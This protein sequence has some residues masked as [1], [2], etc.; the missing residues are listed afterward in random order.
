MKIYDAFDTADSRCIND[1]QICRMS[2]NNNV[3]KVDLSFQCVC[4]YRVVCQVSFICTTI[5]AS[6]HILHTYT[7]HASTSHAHSLLIP[8]AGRRRK[9][10]RTRIGSHEMRAALCGGTA[11]VT[12]G[13]LDALF[14]L[15]A[16]VSVIREQYKPGL[17][18][19]G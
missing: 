5:N 1:A 2:G 7:F 6:D 3:Y 12:M 4:L 14:D 16:R 9:R 11:H 13:L 18:L 10:A 19:R 8:R 15:R 17:L